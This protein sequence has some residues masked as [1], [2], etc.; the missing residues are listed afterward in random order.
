[1]AT[2][3]ITLTELERNLKAVI[4]QVATAGERVLVLAESRQPVAVVISIEEFQILEQLRTTQTSQPAPQRAWLEGARQLQAE[5]AA[6]TG[7]SP[8]PDSTIELNELRQERVDEI[9]GLS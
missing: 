6:R 7:G 1:M 3:E 9:S 4:V 5:I 2:N 8:L